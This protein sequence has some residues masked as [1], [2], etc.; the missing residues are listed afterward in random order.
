MKKN[1]GKNQ[2]KLKENYIIA[3]IDIKDEDINKEIR[4]FNSF[5][6]MKKRYG[7]EDNIINYNKED[8]IEN[9]IKKIIIIKVDNQYLSSFT[10]F[11]KFKTSG[12]HIVQ[13]SFKNNLSN[14][15]YLFSLCDHITKMDFSNFN[16][17]SLKRMN[18]MFADCKALTHLN[19][20]NFNTDK[21][22][23]FDYAYIFTRCDSLKKKNVITE[24]NRILKCL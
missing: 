7:W 13:Y 21:V 1:I 16:S 4:I 5:D 12:I 23:D 6:H 14:A 8:D 15:N 17:E 19:L 24:N 11:Y 2:S 22:I 3:E 10:Y 9:E 20:S 18:S